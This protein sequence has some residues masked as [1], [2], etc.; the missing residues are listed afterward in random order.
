MSELTLMLVGFG[1]LFVECL[2][3]AAPDLRVVEGLDDL[4]SQI[5]EARPDVVTI[6]VAGSNGH[7][8]D[9]VRTVGDAAPQAKVIAYGIDPTQETV[10]KWIE[11]GAHGYLPRDASLSELRR[12]VQLVAAGRMAASPEMAYA[13]FSRL[14]EL[15]RARR[16]TTALE[17]LVLTARELEV[18][19]LIAEGRGNRDIAKELS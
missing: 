9:V 15:A 5:R 11:A 12:T 13:L 16:R 6:D 1:R 8:L 14:A 17:S 19:R 10:L 2:V 7:A 4:E 3:H 18:L